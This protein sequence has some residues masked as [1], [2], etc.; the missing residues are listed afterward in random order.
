[1]NLGKLAESVLS[2]TEQLLTANKFFLPVKSFIIMY[3]DRGEQG[4]MSPLLSV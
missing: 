1:M 3:S 4:R 2:G